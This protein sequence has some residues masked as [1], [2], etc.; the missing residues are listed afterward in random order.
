MQRQEND[1]VL[2][3]YPDPQFLAKTQLAEGDVLQPVVVKAL[4]SIL[5]NSDADRSL[6]P[7]RAVKIYLNRTENIRTTQKKLFIAYKVGHTSEI[8]KG[9][10]SSW[11]KK[12]VVSAYK[13][14]E[15]DGQALRLYRVH[16]HQVRSMAASWAA[17]RQVSM[18]RILTSCSWKSH[19]TFTSF[20]LKDLSL[21]RN[22]LI[23]LGPLS[24]ASHLV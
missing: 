18:E 3:F 23:E 20:Y 17:A 5:D 24:V 12:A 16:G 10:I 6:C 11:L 15:K 14:T 21:F 9:T 19:N 8:C 2:I 13:H 1:R 22:D 7:V 4:T